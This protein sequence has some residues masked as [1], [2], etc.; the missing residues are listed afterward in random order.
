MA[1]QSR[2]IA[3]CVAIALAATTA[4]SAPSADPADYR[5]ARTAARA[6]SRTTQANFTDSEAHPG[7]KVFDLEFCTERDPEVGGATE[8]RTMA[9]EDLAL[10]VSE[11]EAGL[12]RGGYSAAVFAGP[13]RLYEQQALARIAAR[14]AHPRRRG[15]DD[16]W[17]TDADDAAQEASLASMGRAVEAARAR[18]QPRLPPVVVQGGCGAGETAVLLRASP[19]RATVWLIT[20][21]SFDVCKAKGLDPWDRGA[22][23]RWGEVALD[24]KTYLSGSYVY[25]A[26]WA[27]GVKTRGQT[28][29][30]P[31]LDDTGPAQVV[32][33]RQR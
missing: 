24:R 3:G 31:S 19:A 32:W 16:P 28:S 13:L 25:Q 21:F 22:C 4:A 20:Q 33:I 6:L 14:T 2:L 11:M 27:G 12:T 5:A 18:L 30:T 7:R 17:A 15:S 26:Q 9:L 1:G 29:V 8:G 10:K 23:G